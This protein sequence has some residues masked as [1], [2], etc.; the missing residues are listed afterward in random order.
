MKSGNVD[1]LCVNELKKKT[2]DKIRNAREIR[3]IYEMIIYSI[4]LNQWNFLLGNNEIERK[5]NI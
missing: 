1:F 5:S 4:G 3:G 2:V